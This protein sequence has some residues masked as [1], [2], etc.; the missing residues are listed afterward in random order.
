MSRVVRSIG[1]VA[2][3]AF[4]VATV[5]PRTLNKSKFGRVVLAAAAIYF[6]GPAIMGAISGASTAAAAGTSMMSGAL[7]GA[8]AGLSGAVAG[9]QTAAGAIAKEGL[10]R[11]AMGQAAQSLAQGF[12]GGG[13]VGDVAQ[14]AVG[15]TVRS[16]ST[17]LAEAAVT[18]ATNSAGPGIVSQALN[19]RL[20]P[21]ALVVGG[22]MLA[23]RA[24][25]K[26][27]E[28]QY[29]RSNRNMGQPQYGGFFD[30]RAFPRG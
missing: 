4:K 10:T 20:A 1:K 17:R 11:Q 9:L 16:G 24:Q 3:A 21:A 28:A 22:N 27:A 30:W 2:K 7:S 5:V 23:G 15:N 25:E 26:A 12:T 19:S 14:Q 8:Q 6:G 29:Q 18:G 13:A